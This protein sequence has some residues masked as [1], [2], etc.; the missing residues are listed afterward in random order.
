[1]RK[2]ITPKL[3]PRDAE[4]LSRELLSHLPAY[5]PEWQVQE[6]SAPWALIH[7]TAR[8][9][10][11]VIQR[12]NKAPDKNLLAFLD[13]LGISLIPAQGARA[14]IVFEVPTDSQDGRAP[15]GTRL[16]ASA[17]TAAASPVIFETES[18]IGL[19][20]A[21][22]TDV[23]S[24][25]PAKDSYAVHSSDVAGERDFTLFTSLK[26]VPHILYLAHDTLCAL[27][28]TATLKID[29]Q[30]ASGQS[31]KWPEVV[32]EYWNGKSWLPL[33]VTA[34][35][36]TGD[37][38]KVSLKKNTGDK[39]AKTK[40]NGVNAY[41][42]RGRLSKPLTPATNA[43]L[44]QLEKIELLS[45]IDQKSLE[46]DQAMSEGT[47]LDLTKAFLPLGQAPRPGAVFYFSCEE[48]FSKPGA[49][50]SISFTKAELPETE[51]DAKSKQFEA[52]VDAARKYLQDAADKA[53]KVAYDAGQQLYNALNPNAAILLKSRNKEL[54][55]ARKKLV[56]QTST[57]SL[58]D[59]IKK[60]Q[61]AVK[62]VQDAIAIVWNL[63]NTPVAV[64]L[65][66]FDIQDIKDEVDSANKILTA[67]SKLGPTTAVLS[68]SGKTFEVTGPQ[69]AW[70]YWNGS[71][72]EAL[73]GPAK[74][75]KAAINFKAD[76]D[77]NNKI[78]FTVPSDWVAKEVD[79]VTTR[80][81]RVRLAKGSYDRLRIVSWYDQQEKR[82]NALPILEARP[83][84]LESFSLGY[85][86]TPITKSPPQY[87]LCYND[88]QYVEHSKTPL[89]GSSFTPF[90][91]ISDRT[92]ALYLGFDKPLPVD[93]IGLYCDIAD[94][95]GETATPLLTWEMWDGLAWQELTV[96]DETADLTRPG[97]VSFIAETSAVTPREATIS[98]AS[99]AQ[100]VVTEALEAARFDAGDRVYLKQ[101]KTGEMAIVDSVKGSTIQLAVPL[102]NTY[103]GGQIQLSDLPRFGTPRTWVRARL[104]E[105]GEPPFAKFSGLFL[106][107]VWATERQTFTDEVMGSSNEQADQVFFFKQTPVLAGAQ[108]EVREL[109]G[110][111]A[112]VELPLL[113]EELEKQ[114]LTED[115][116]RTVKDKRTDRVNEVWVS[117]QVRPH[118]YFSGSDDRHCMIEQARGRLIFGDGNLG[119]IPPAGANNILARRYQAGG[120][121]T[122]NVKTRAIKQLL[123]LAFPAQSVF[124][125][126]AAE[127]GADGETLAAVRYRGPEAV[128]HRWRAVSALDY[129]SLAKEA[130]PGVALA[131]A[132][133]TTDASG[134]YARGWVSV[135]IVPRS[136]AAQPQPSAE[137]KRRV[138]RYLAARAPAGIAGIHVADPTY[139]LVGVTTTVAPCDIQEAGIVEQRVRAT[140][141]AFLHPL[142]GGPD[143]TGWPFGRDV[144]LSDLAAMLEALEGVDYVKELSFSIGGTNQGEHVPVPTN[145]LVAAGTIHI[146][147]SAPESSER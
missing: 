117:W 14:P 47:S 27:A 129:E 46:A 84:M 76:T 105:D 92:P 122:G 88:F 19:T 113:I 58:I 123:G 144:Y 128:R 8:M 7:T 12:L 26:S 80:W 31:G 99:G 100:V 34:S 118:L 56:S 63:A 140:L 120:G 110:A 147:L 48:A 85:S 86:Y 71:Q 17:G 81:M 97:M 104:K 95:K 43:T 53:A 28:G 61:E 68:T 124:N 21:K 37:V 103:S 16:G 146:R 109:S 45:K 91:P 142:S 121:K 42:V 38:T 24:L 1:M 73:L 119:K 143:G 51:A 13:M 83:P 74:G 133:P 3:D 22:L 65:P 67:L 102:G 66:S 6:G 69:L 64:L 96:T 101:N 29:L 15:A 134:N 126:R 87:C 25:W 132:L 59:R 135:I 20:G 131:R 138:K 98:K 116:V 50:V 130:S 136:K 114:G 5:V 9:I 23:I 111:R 33:T 82:T 93:V 137:L 39:S 106:N 75:D 32:W 107:A 94:E 55:D 125:P 70:E 89:G 90:R 54:D 35:T 11:A 30:L 141:K 18:A 78:S 112:H 108:I 57:D 52:S 79:G 115:D 72:W 77:S 60:V 10:Q 127:G 139:L 41:W 40:V 2:Q 145:R 44:P 49:Q 4:S 36:T 62:N